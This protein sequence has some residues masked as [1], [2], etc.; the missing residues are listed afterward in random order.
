MTQ[1]IL[2]APPVFFFSFRLLLQENVVEEIRNTLFGR[3]W[4]ACL[5]V[6]RSLARSVVAKSDWKIVVVVV[7][8]LEP[9]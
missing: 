1:Y 5:C 8:V 2:I 3:Q 6:E 7:V 9:K 4:R